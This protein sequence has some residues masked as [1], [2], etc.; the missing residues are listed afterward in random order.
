LEVFSAHKNP[1]APQLYKSIIFSLC[2]HFSDE[3]SREFIFTQ[4]AQ[5]YKQVPSIPVD[6]LIDPLSQVL[7][8]SRLKLFDY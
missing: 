8:K 2:E 5:L 4:L 3:V 6:L 1:A 7:N